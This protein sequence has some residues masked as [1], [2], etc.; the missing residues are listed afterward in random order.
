MNARLEVVTPLVLT[1]NEEANIGRVLESLQWA[2]RII[3]VDSGSTDGTEEIC[4]N[5]PNVLW[6]VRVFDSHAAQWN[7]GIFESGIE[8]EYVLALDGDMEVPA[9]VAEE[10]GQEFLPRE[11]DGGVLGFQFRMGGVPLSGSLYPPDLRIFR[12]QN[13]RVQQ[14]GHTQ[15]FFA[16]GATYRFK[17]RLV[18]D[19]RKSVDRWV[20]S[21]VRYSLLEAT[22]LKDQPNGGFR[23]SMRRAGVM[24]LLAGLYAYCRSGGPFKGQASL[25][26]AYQRAV[27]EAI[28][29]M[30]LFRSSAGF[31]V[32]KS[33]V[34][35]EC[36]GERD[37]A[38]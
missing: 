10:L 26:Y 34:V 16:I 7:Y 4:R 32:G 37:G 13:V 15:R 20:D 1:Y 9:A 23:R 25:E 18:H 21:Q 30:R 35:T 27:Y 5:Y 11:F 36:R 33:G 19:D 8:T 38:A 24:P 6:R 3:V 2:K 14:V 29:A 31:A 17:N 22:Y 28:L 12:K